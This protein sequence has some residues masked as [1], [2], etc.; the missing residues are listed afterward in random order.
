MSYLKIKE[1]LVTQF[2][3]DKGLYHEARISDKS[4]PH[5]IISPSKVVW[6]LLYPI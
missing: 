2:L 1:F 3:G 4:T 6:T 5:L